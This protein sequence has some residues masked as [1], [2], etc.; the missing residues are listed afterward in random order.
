MFDGITDLKTYHETTQ[1][2]DVFITESI[3]LVEDTLRCQS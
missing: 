1:L 2:S 3:T